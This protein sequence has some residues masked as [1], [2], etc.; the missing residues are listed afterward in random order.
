MRSRKVTVEQVRN[1]V[2]LLKFSDVILDFIGR[3]S[4]REESALRLRKVFSDI[5]STWK[6]LVFDAHPDRGGNLEDFQSLQS[7]WGLV[8]RDEFAYVLWE[9]ANGKP[10]RQR[11]RFEV[12]TPFVT[13]RVVTDQS[14]DPSSIG[15]RFTSRSRT[16]TTISTGFSGFSE[17]DPF[18]VRRV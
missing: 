18:F 14:I 11:S 6:K 8:Q 17:G 16:A 13:V 12:K 15:I 9:V 7:A 10:Q 4:S 5:K 3:A 2:D 1:A